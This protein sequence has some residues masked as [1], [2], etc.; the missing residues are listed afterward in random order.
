MK[1]TYTLIF[2]KDPEEGYVVEV[3]ELPG[4]L[5]WGKDLTQAKEKI[6]EAIS[7]Y[8]EAQKLVKSK[9]EVFIDK[10]EYDAV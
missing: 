8:L 2:K 1:K 4:C 3:A 10:L 7:A 9:Q 5:S 6:K